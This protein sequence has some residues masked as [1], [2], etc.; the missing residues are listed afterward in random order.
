MRSMNE[1]TIINLT[2]EVKACA[3]VESPILAFASALLVI[4]T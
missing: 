3:F 1:W 2:S 4:E